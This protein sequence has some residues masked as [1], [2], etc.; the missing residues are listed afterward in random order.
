MGTWG[1]KLNENDTFCEIYDEFIDLYNDNFE[2]VEITNRWIRIN[3]EILNTD[4]DSNN[5]WFA[6]AKEQW[7]CKNLQ[8]EIFEK[9]KY[10]IEKEIDIEIWKKLEASETD[11][12]KRRIEL[13]KFLASLK[14]ERKDVLKR[15]RKKLY[16]S[17]FV[18]GDCVSYK[19]RNG[20]YG[21]AFVLTDEKNCE[22]GTNYIAMTT[23]NKVEKPNLDDFK[24]AEIYVKKLKWHDLPQIGYISKYL[25]DKEI[26]YDIIG[27]LSI[28]KNFERNPHKDFGFVW[29]ALEIEIPQKE[30]YEKLNGKA[31]KK[32]YVNEWV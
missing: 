13:D 31:E 6:I 7:M 30:N 4:E 26:S 24:K 10:I 32:L 8:L 11:L 2:V 19:M 21:G 12:G 14:T 25:F 22:L 1:I 18:K 15:K 27:N 3:S 5:F 29:A 17:L 20:N 16:N 23:I 9:V 28:I